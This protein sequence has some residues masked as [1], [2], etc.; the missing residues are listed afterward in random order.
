MQ[1]K[2]GQL[3]T[4]S[5]VHNIFYAGSVDYRANTYCGSS[6]F[7]YC[8]SLKE[9][10]WAAGLSTN[11]GY[12]RT[13][14]SQTIGTFSTSTDFF[15]KVKNAINANQPVIIPSNWGYPNVGH[16]WVVVGY[17]DWGTPAGSALYLRDVA[18]SSPVAPNADQN[19]DVQIFYNATPVKQMLIIK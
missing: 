2:T 16:F 10:M 19:A 18:L 5:Q 6:G 12:G 9:L 7:Q 1:Y 15:T 4:L 14:I 17:T 11:G 3:K 8:A 13:A